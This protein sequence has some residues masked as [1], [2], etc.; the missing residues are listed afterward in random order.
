MFTYKIYQSNIHFWQQQ[1]KLPMVQTPL[2]NNLKKK[3]RGIWDCRAK[4]EWCARIMT[5]LKKLWTNHLGD[6]KQ[7]T[8]TTFKCVGFIF[9]STVQ[10]EIDINNR[11]N[12]AVCIKS[13]TTGVT[14]QEYSRARSSRLLSARLGCGPGVF[15]ARRSRS[16]TTRS[17]YSGMRH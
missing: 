7:N 1:S 2:E 5:I 9:D 13:I 10:L 14:G 8:V 4:P 16:V 15:R 17:S 6:E 11:V 12:I 3:N